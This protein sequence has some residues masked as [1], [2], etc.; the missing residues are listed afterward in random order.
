MTVVNCTFRKYLD[1]L[2]KKQ[3][4]AVEIMLADEAKGLCTWRITSSNGTE[5]PL[6]GNPDWH[7]ELEVMETVN[8]AI[9]IRVG[10]RP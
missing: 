1:Y 9:G 3:G 8:D 10:A 2:E 7:I 4:C 6:A 5:Y